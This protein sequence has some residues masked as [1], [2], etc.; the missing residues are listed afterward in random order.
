[1]PK[2]YTLNLDAVLVHVVNDYLSILLLDFVESWYQ[3]E[4]LAKVIKSDLHA[5]DKA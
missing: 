4:Q 3:T 2:Q 1:M 5:F